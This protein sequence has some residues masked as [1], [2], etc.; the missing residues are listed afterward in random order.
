MARPGMRPSAR[1]SGI[2]EGAGL[3]RPA[4]GQSIELLQRLVVTFLR[5]RFPHPARALVVAQQAG[6]M[7]AGRLA[8]W[9]AQNARA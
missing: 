6:A 7:D 8:Q 9:L 5:Q 3:A 1:I 4:P 2:A